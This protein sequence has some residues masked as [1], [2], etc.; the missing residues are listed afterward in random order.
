MRSV[1]LVGALLLVALAAPVQAAPPAG[2]ER[3]TAPSFIGSFQATVDSREAT[4]SPDDPVV[5]CDTAATDNTVWFRYTPRSDSQAEITTQGDY[6]DEAAGYWPAIL[7]LAG[8]DVVACVPAATTDCHF[9]GCDVSD[10][11]VPPTLHW[12]F[13]GRTSFDILIAHRGAPGTFDVTLYE[14]GNLLQPVVAAF[15]QSAQEVCGEAT[16]ADCSGEPQ[17][18]AVCEVVRAQG[19]S[20]ESPPGGVGGLVCF[21]LHS[22]DVSCEWPEESYDGVCWVV[23]FYSG[24]EGCA[25]L[26]P[27]ELLCGSHEMVDGWCR[28]MPFPPDDDPLGMV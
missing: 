11:S 27:A 1:V 25:G 6:Y 15:D 4:A 18:E 2:D 7:V 24:I 10:G 26:E 20:C 9:M 22:L 14:S 17:E 5:S 19:K 23:G 3:S 12:T 21:Y 13:E 16:G 28:G 8:P